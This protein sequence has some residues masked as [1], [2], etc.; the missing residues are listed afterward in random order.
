MPTKKL[1]STL[2]AVCVLT[3]AGVGSSAPPKSGKVRMQDFVEKTNLLLGYPDGPPQ[4]PPGYYRRVLATL[5]LHGIGGPLY[6]PNPCN[7][8]IKVY[9]VI[10]DKVPE[11]PARQH[12][13][14]AVLRN[15]ARKQCCVDLVRDGSVDETQEP[16]TI[17]SLRPVLCSAQ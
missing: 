6:P 17:L 9:N 15:M 14:D 10:I 7:N 8:L 3:L 2:A 13:T 5:H 16:A 1:T 11:G 4:T 12:A